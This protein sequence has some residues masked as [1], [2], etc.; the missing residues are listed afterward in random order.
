MQT[1]DR[2]ELPP[3]KVFFGQPS[4]ILGQ[5]LMKGCINIRVTQQGLYLSH[6]SPL[7]YLITPLMIDWNA[8]AKIETTTKA[9]WGNG[10]KFY[11]GN[12]L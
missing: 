2:S 1:E 12:P 9:L 6:T 10:Y 11:L 8:I 3:P 4:C 5:T 7:N